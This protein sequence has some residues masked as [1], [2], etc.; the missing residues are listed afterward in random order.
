MSSFTTPFIGELIGKY[1]F[2][3]Y[4]PFEYHV[5]KYPSNEIIKVPVGFV[6][7][8][9]SIP[10]AFWSILP[11]IDNYAKAA[12]IHDWLYWEGIYTRKK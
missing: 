1:T 3:V 6:T 8:F 10:R 4:S 2:K 7:D 12:V 11:P 5:G 9:A